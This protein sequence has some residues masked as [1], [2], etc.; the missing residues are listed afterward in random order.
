[1][2]K[3]L[4][5]IIASVAVSTVFAQVA[6]PS[7]ATNQHAIFPNPTTALLPSV[8]IMDAVDANVVWV[9]GWDLN[10]PS[11]NYNWYSRSINAGVTF[12][13]GTIYSDT[14][15]YVIGNMEGI[16]ANTAWV[17][18]FKKVGPGSG[19][20]GGA[21]HRTTNGGATWSNMTASGM[22]TNTTSFA[23]FITFLTPSVAIANGDPIN[24]EFELWRSTDAGLTWSLTPG[25]NIP[26]PTS[27]EFAIVNL[28]A[29]VGTSNLWFGTNGDR[30]FRTTDAG[31][32]YSASPV[33]GI[34]TNTITEIAFSSPLNG[35][36]IE[37]NAS[38]VQELWH[39]SDGG[40]TWSQISPVPTNMGTWDITPI[41]GTGYLV[42]YDAGTNSK[43]SYSSDN[44]VTWTD[45]G[46]T[47][48]PYVTGDFVDGTTGWA[49]GIDFTDANSNNFTN[50][51]KYTGTAISGTVSPSAA[52]SLPP[53]ICIGSSAST[54]VP[55]NTSLGSP[56]LSYSWS[57]VGSGATLSSNTASAP[58]I[59]FPSA[60][61]YTVVLT[62]TNTIGANTSSFVINVIACSAPVSSFSVANAC[63]NVSVVTNNSSTGSPSPSYFW[64]VSPSNVTITPSP[65]AANPAFLF[66]TTGTYSITL[67]TTNAT[68]STST[69]QTVSAAP[70][71]AT[72]SI[73]FNF[74]CNAN[75]TFTTNASF[76]NPVG[77]SMTYTWSV[78]PSANVT[79]T[80]GVSSSNVRVGLG[81]AATGDYTITVKVRNASGTATITQVITQEMYT[82]NY[83]GLA[84]NTSLSNVL[85]IYPNPAHDQ[86][87]VSLPASVD[88]YKVKLTNILGAVVYEDKAVKNTKENVINLSNKPKGVYFLTVETN[89]EKA[90]KKIVIE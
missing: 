68:G 12:S 7:W 70:C 40:A 87:S 84:E 33:S 56:S 15:T 51:W 27:G 72:G 50:V 24:G 42:S 26:N 90:T 47:G 64:S 8:K 48:I 39:T 44:G 36:C 76:A 62:A 78:A 29:K 38:S 41:P 23:N 53:T 83:V 57:V 28:Y 10:A 22:F 20:G 59:T 17:C 60:N 30:M 6:S 21:I 19:Q 73:G 61:V 4:L 31:I 35:V 13:G 1:M 54:V 63:N 16:D 82:C 66:S 55:V 80:G 45:W 52:F 49:G 75:R 32:T 25:A 46:S 77:G 71:V 74:N 67:V 14:N 37:V 86:I 65:V 81:A 5:S 11:R 2:K 3:Q 79:Y 89:N 85:S 18:A 43:I 9:T 88:T 69:T 58:T 34:A